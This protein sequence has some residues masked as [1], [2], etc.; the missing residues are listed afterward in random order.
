[1]SYYINWENFYKDNKTIND[2]Y[3]SVNEIKHLI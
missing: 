3:V 1:M 2:I